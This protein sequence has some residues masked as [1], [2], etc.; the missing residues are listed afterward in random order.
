MTQNPMEILAQ[1]LSGERALGV[2]PFVDLAFP[3]LVGPS[4]GTEANE[5]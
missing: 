5:G 3:A 2:F 4:R 1:A